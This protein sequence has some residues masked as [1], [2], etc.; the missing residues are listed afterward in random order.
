M[1]GPGPM[2]TKNLSYTRYIYFPGE[3]VM[4]KLRRKMLNFIHDFLLTQLIRMQDILHTKSSCDSQPF[5]AQRYSVLSQFK[6]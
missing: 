4:V 3:H 1:E 6:R 2:K 5:G